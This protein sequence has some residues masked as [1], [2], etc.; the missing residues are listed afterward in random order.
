MMRVML[1]YREGSLDQAL[2]DIDYL[3]DHHREELDE[4][5]ILE[6]RDRLERERRA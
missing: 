1:F 2:A 3:L 4:E 5:R 6:L